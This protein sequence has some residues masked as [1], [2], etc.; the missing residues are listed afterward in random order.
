M[1]RRTA[2]L[3]LGAAAGAWAVLRVQR[4]AARLT[5]SGAAGDLRRWV[6]HL[7]SDVAAALEEG[8]RTQRRVEAGIR[9]EHHVVGRSPVARPIDATAT[10][11]VAALD[12]TAP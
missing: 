10:P 12:R 5:P 9:A 8:A 6:R 1:L 3:L 11:A 2:W 7:H 4:A